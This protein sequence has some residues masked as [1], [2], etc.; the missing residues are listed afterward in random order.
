MSMRKVAPPSAFT[1]P[2]RNSDAYSDD[3]GWPLIS[4]TLSVLDPRGIERH[5]AKY[6]LVYRSHLFGE[7]SQCC[8]DPTPRR[9]CCSTRP[10]SS[11]DAGLG[12]NSRPLFPRGPALDFEEHRL[13]ARCRSRSNRSDEILSCRVDT[14]IA[15]R[16]RN[17]KRSRDRYCSA[18]KQLTLDLAAPR[19]GRRNGP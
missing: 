4:Q 8:S 11:L 16:S 1:P 13:P 19:F 12:P 18:M 17:G 3:E 6:G 9:W 5:A 2:K 14:G 10:S 7:T 15:S